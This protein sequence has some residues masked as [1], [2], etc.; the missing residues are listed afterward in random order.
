MARLI[1]R[2]VGGVGKWMLSN[3]AVVFARTSDS[4]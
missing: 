3:G 2:G 1:E 4:H